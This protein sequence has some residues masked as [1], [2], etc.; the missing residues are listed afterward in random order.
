MACTGAARFTL[1]LATPPYGG[2]PACLPEGAWE[3]GRLGVEKVTTSADRTELGEPTAPAP[4]FA[5]PLPA[6]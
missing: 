5:R 1:S 4:P 2:L 6:R 3:R